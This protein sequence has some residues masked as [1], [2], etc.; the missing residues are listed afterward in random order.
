[1][2][3][4]SGPAGAASGGKLPDL[5]ESVIALL[6][7]GL[8]ATLLSVVDDEPG[9]PGT[10]GGTEAPPAGAV[11]LAEEG[12]DEGRDRLRGGHRGRGRLLLGLEPGAAGLR[13]DRTDAG[14]GQAV[15]VGPGLAESGSATPLGSASPDA[16]GSRGGPGRPTIGGDPARRRRSS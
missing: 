7:C 2:E 10:T 9:P 8:L 12:E 14:R 16:R 13:G 15:E 4:A 1:M 11:L 6:G 3:A 5:R